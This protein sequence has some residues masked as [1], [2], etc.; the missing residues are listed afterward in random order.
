MHNRIAIIIKIM[1]AIIF[2][3]GIVAVVAVPLPLLKS[4]DTVEYGF[5]HIGLG[6]FVSFVI[7]MLI[8]GFG[9]LIEKADEQ[10][11]YQKEIFRIVSRFEIKGVPSYKVDPD[12]TNSSAIAENN[13]S[14]NQRS[15]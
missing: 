6:V 13:N 7:S 14:I 5:I 15:E 4:G 2:V 3:G 1:S 11:G 10:A 12:L 9:E 8:N